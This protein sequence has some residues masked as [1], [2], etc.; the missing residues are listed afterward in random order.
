MQTDVE[1]R[2]AGAKVVDTGVQSQE[3]GIRRVEGADVGQP[4][5]GWGGVRAGVVGT[6]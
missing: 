1:R 3:R 6:V 2:V 5:G 4:G